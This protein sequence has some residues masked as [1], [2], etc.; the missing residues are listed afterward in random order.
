MTMG[1]DYMVGMA[2]GHECRSCNSQFCRLFLFPFTGPIPL[3]SSL[4]L[5]HLLWCVLRTYFMFSSQHWLYPTFKKNLALPLKYLLLTLH[6]DYSPSTIIFISYPDERILH[7]FAFENTVLF[8]ISILLQWNE[9]LGIKV[10]VLVLNFMPIL[11]IIC[12]LFLHVQK[13]YLQT[14]RNQQARTFEH[15]AQVRGWSAHTPDLWNNYE[16]KSLVKKTS[17]SQSPTI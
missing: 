5:S 16:N 8:L 3:L 15:T 12:L 9:H 1:Q 14:P 6:E 2:Q 13:T 4:H 11:F 10:L 17:T 7:F